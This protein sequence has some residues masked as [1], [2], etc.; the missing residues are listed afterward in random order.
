[1]TRQTGE[2]MSK[3]LYSDH[4]RALINSLIKRRQLIK[5]EPKVWIDTI[6]KNLK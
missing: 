5:S 3:Y 6:K 1:M 4:M 2:D